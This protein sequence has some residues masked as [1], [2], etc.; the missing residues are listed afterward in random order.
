MSRRAAYTK[1]FDDLV[2]LS[3]TGRLQAASIGEGKLAYNP[4]HR[5]NAFEMLGVAGLTNVV[6]PFL[7]DHPAIRRFTY[8]DLREAQGIS[9]NEMDHLGVYRALFLAEAAK[10][11]RRE[12][13]DASEPPVFSVLLPI[14]KI[15][16]VDVYTPK[17]NGSGCL[18]SLAGGAALALGGT[19]LATGSLPPD[20]IPAAVG[21]AAYFA[22]GTVLTSAALSRLHDYTQ[23]IEA[24]QYYQQAETAA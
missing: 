21:S 8:A 1:K 24:A 17:R 14:T 4:F 13:T 7:S 9:G 12:D 5:F 3:Q 22:G 2:E 15:E 18:V 23:A 16:P 11:V 10:Y 19:E 20:S 6:A